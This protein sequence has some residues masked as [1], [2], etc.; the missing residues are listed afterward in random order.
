M[1]V[2]IV[3]DSLMDRRLLSSALKKNNVLNEVLEAKD[4]QEGL[5]VL[6][7]NLQDICLILLDWQMPNMN[8]I[9]FMKAVRQVPQAARIPI[10][11]ISA[12][13]SD[14]NKQQAREANPDLA[15]YV[16]KPYSPVKLVE[17]IR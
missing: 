3:D 12:S 14:E 1:K 9:D 17:L 10:F 7:E 15:G 11:M 5:K 6:S 2:L 16:V 4:G 8:G 13:G